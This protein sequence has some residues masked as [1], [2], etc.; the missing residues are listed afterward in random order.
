MIC[1]WRASPRRKAK[2]ERQQWDSAKNAAALEPST[3]FTDDR[4]T[5]TNAALGNAGVE[6]IPL[7]GVE[8]ARG[9]RAL[10][11]RSSGTGRAAKALASPDPVTGTASSTVHPVVEVPFCGHTTKG[12]APLRASRQQPPS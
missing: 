5:R 1:I 2:R 8:F 10:L 9:G 12:A 7:V 6:A 3:V 11:D 4:N